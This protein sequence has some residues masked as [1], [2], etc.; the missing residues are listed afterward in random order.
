LD[1]NIH[2]YFFIDCFRNCFYFI[3]TIFIGY[4]IIEKLKLIKKPLNPSNSKLTKYSAET[5]IYLQIKLNPM[6]ARYQEG[7]FKPLEKIKDIKEGEVV[8]I[9][10]ERH[11]WNKLAMANPS[12]EFLKNEPDIYS[13]KDI[14]DSE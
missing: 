9:S 6:K 13:G 8:E 5:F 4:K 11:E 14:I 2:V 1:N 3:G 7:V 12:F 10:I